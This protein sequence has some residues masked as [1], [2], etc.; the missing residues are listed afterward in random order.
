MRKGTVL[1][2]ALSLLMF[3]VGLLLIRL[4]TVSRVDVIQ[5]KETIVT[6]TSTETASIPSSIAVYLPMQTL[7]GIN[8]TGPLKGYEEG[9]PVVQIKDPKGSLIYSNSTFPPPS[10]IEFD[11][12]VTGWYTIDLNIVFGN[13]STVEV[14]Y[15]SSSPEIVYPY[16]NWLYPGVLIAVLAIIGSAASLFLAP[17]WQRTSKA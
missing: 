6:Y 17:K 2:I 10:I 15:Y 3:F 5:S 14:Y 1:A 4:S 9:L 16:R 13:G 7:S 8:M 12:T 11:T